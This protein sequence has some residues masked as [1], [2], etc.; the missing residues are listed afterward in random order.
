MGQLGW[1]FGLPFDECVLVWHVA[2]DLCSRRTTNTSSS[3]G[4]TIPS[5]RNSVIIS[6]HM[7]YLLFV[8]PEMLM[9][10]TRQD[11]FMIACG[12]IEAMIKDEPLPSLD[13]GSIARRILG[14]ERGDDDLM[15]K[16]PMIS[17]ARKL[18]EALIGLDDEGKRWE[19]IQ[20]VWVEMLCYSA[21][22]C[23]GYEHAKS[24]AHGGEFLTNV[25]LL[26]SCMGMETLPDKIHNPGIPGPLESDPDEEHAPAA[27]AASG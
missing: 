14:V 9:V 16:A 12:E 2:T 26:W 20:G 25:W 13:E 27:G 10:G 11:L 5:R 19:V 1:S 4:D 24:L 22:R 17:N 8:C 21:S 7:I 15:K 3:Q 18:A 23:R 6:N